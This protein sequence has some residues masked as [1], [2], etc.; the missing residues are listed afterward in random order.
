MKDTIALLSGS[1]GAATVQVAEKTS[2][3][4]DNLITD[5]MQS[6]GISLVVGIIALFVNRL[7]ERLF[8]KKVPKKVD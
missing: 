4:I 7:F 8:G 2:P 1:A 3:I 5:D 6:A